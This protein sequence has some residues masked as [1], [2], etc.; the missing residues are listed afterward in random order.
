MKVST[1]FWDVGGVLLRTEDPRPR[2]LLAAQFGKSRQELDELVWGGELGRAAQLGEIT[3]AE[4]WAEVGRQLG[5]PAAGL[6]HFREEFFAGDRL[7]TSLLAW[8]RQLKTHYK[9][10]II[11]NAMSDT[12]AFLTEQLQ[13]S[14][15]FDDMVFSAEIHLMKPDPRIYRLALDRLGVEAEAAFFV[16]DSR[17]NVD[18]ARRLGMKAVHFRN[19]RETRQALIKLLTELPDGDKP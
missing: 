13:I 18:G 11:S 12:R 2:E 5:I 14:E 10:G 16:D 1:I 8:I 6:V 4:R 15:A 3:A 7:D 19:P 9:I 17:P